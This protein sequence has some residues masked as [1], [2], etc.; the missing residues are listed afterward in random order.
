MSWSRGKERE[1]LT[2]AKAKNAVF[3]SPS[4]WLHRLQLFLIFHDEKKIET[5]ITNSS[6]IEFIHNQKKKFHEI[7]KMVLNFGK[8]FHQI[9]I[10]QF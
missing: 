6:K 8:F 3:T 5:V 10:R 2:F 7:K 1:T 4:P 9:F